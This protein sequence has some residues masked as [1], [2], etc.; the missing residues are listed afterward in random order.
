[1]PKKTTTVIFLYIVFCC[2]MKKTINFFKKQ[3]VIIKIKR[4]ALKDYFLRDRMIH[5]LAVITDL[6]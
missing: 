5:N 1:M 2:A 3:I 6:P 4:S